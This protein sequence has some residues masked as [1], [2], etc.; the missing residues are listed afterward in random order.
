MIMWLLISELTVFHILNI[1]KRKGKA[2]ISLITWSKTKCIDIYFL[3]VYKIIFMVS[4]LYQ[5]VSIQVQLLNQPILSLH[6]HLLN[7][8]SIRFI[9]SQLL[10]LNKILERFQKLLSINHKFNLRVTNKCLLNFYNTSKC[11][12]SAIKKISTVLLLTRKKI[13][14][15][16]T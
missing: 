16:K 12:W 1:L 13:R 11:K 3:K 5:L 7:I 15:L 14:N 8:F 6:L 4:H 2:W 10:I 9:N